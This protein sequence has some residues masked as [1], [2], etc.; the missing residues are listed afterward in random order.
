MVTSRSSTYIGKKVS[1]RFM[2]Y[3]KPDFYRDHIPY[4]QIMLSLILLNILVNK[5]LIAQTGFRYFKIE[6]L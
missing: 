4:T 2:Q 3:G 6:F 1:L 5:S